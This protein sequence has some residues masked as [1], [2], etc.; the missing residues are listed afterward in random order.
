MAR[1]AQGSRRR[2]PVIYIV[3]EGSQTE[4]R[5]FRRFR[6]RDSIIDI[7]PVD[8]K[9]KSAVDIVKNAQ[10]SIMPDI[11]YPSD[12]DQIWCV[13]DRDSNTNENLSEAE[14]LAGKS[15]YRIAYSNPAFELWFLL[16]FVHQQGY[17]EDCDDAIRLLSQN[18][19]LPGYTK[20]GDYFELLRA[21]MGAVVERAG[22][23]MKRH[24]EDRNTLLCRESNPCTTVGELVSFLLERASRV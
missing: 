13:F 18:G 14:R 9:K 17:I 7:H 16:H 10:R 6:T 1:Q 21:N 2:R 22:M 19:R 12:G 3:C 24:L 8:S 23:L 15:G 20:T 5:Y 4:M 11:Y